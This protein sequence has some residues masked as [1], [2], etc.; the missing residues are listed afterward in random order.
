[1]HRNSEI[2]RGGGLERKKDT[3]TALLHHLQKFPPVGGNWRVESALTKI[4]GNT[5]ENGCCD[6]I[7]KLPCS[8][9]ELNYTLYHL[10]LK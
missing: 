2:E 6:V 9:S 7:F 1:M 10:T 4:S 8:K 5:I 3:P